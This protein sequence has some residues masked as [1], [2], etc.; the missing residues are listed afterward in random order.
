MYTIYF[1]LCKFC[2][3][4]FSMNGKLGYKNGIIDGL[5]ICFAYL[6]VSFTFGLTVTQNGLS[7][8]LCRVEEV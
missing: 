7:W 6:A 1:E 4:I 3:K 2:D 8:V 5:P